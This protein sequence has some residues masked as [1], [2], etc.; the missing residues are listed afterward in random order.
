MNLEQALTVQT[1]PESVLRAQLAAGERLLWTGRP[2]AGWLREDYRR[3]AVAPLY[4]LLAALLAWL[5]LFLKAAGTTGS[6]SLA[7]VYLLA[8]L[9][10]TI[11]RPIRDV[12]RRANTI[13]AVT[14]RRILVVMGRRRWKIESYPLRDLSPVTLSGELPDGRGTI[15]F[16]PA[17]LFKLIEQP[18]E[19]SET[20]RRAQ[21]AVRFP[22][23]YPRPPRPVTAAT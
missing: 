21:M 22:E 20:V 23:S 9:V 2:H 12:L 6:V 10:H 4:L 16:G 14:D 18:R 1:T 8:S 11:A 3:L 13:Y 17:L 5:M 19:V 7:G 15:Q